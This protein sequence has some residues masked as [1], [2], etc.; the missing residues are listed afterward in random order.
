MTTDDTT[1]S[2]PPE[3]MQAP[4]PEEEHQ[5]LA[6]LLGDW[7]F[8]GEAEMGEGKP[9]AKFE[10]RESVRALG[11]VWI[12]SE[13]ES[14]LPDGGVARSVMTLGYNPQKQRFTGTFISSMMTHLWL[15]EGTLDE[16]QR[17]LTLASEGPGMTP[18]TTARYKD[19]IE[20][21]GD[22]RRTMSS[23]VEGEGGS[24]NRIMTMRY[25]RA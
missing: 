2:Q 8:D 1:D 9:P 25:R 7:T 14:P 5:W 17:V 22:D 23:F 21:D 15:Y 4:E 3:G 19:V 13:G 10:G 6:Q 18:G 24:W 16:A 20:I 11:E 12:L